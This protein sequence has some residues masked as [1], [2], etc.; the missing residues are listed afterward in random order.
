MLRTAVE[1]HP[2]ATVVPLDGRSAYDCISRAAVL[3]RLYAHDA[4]SF[5]GGTSPLGTT[6]TS[7]RRR[8][9]DCARLGSSCRPCRVCPTCSARSFPP[10][11]AADYARSPNDE[12]WRTL[13]ELLGGLDPGDAA[14]HQHAQDWEA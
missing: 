5:Y 12:V 6:S 11:L 4:L 2:Q 14:S 9:N 1:L 10:E 3:T 13:L 7:G 8:G